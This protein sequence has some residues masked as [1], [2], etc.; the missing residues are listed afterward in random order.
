MPPGSTAARCGWPVSGVILPTRL[1]DAA[2]Q[3]L[4]QLGMTSMHDAGIGLAQDRL[5]REYAAQGRLPLRI[6]GMLRGSGETL[7]A[8]RQHDAQPLRGPFY[9]LAA[10]K[11]FADGA[12]GSRGAALLAPYSDQPDKRGL[13][14]AADTE[15]QAQMAKAMALGYQ[16]N[17]HAI[18]DAANR[19]VLEM[20]ARLQQAHPEWRALRPRIEH[21]QVIALPDIARFAQLGVIASVQPVH[22]TSD[23]NMAEARVG[24]RIAGAYA[25][26]R[27]QQAGARLACGSDFPVEAP[28]PWHGLHAAISRSDADGLPRGGWYAEQSLSL[29][30]ALSCFTL[31]AA[32]AAH[33]DQEQGSLEPGKWADF[34]ILPQ[35]PFTITPAALRRMQVL[36]TWVGGRQ[37]WAQP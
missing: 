21:A 29:K 32:W 12:L 5:L 6:Y 31:D 15:L 13:L 37:V 30:E 35:D 2:L 34:I 1:V 3:L 10:V 11:L 24:A 7:D 19:Q 27:L 23:M 36:Q 8:I 16:V 17:V 28:N 9:S 18:G 25:W 4:P 33:Q 22:A 20:H 14:F 26:R